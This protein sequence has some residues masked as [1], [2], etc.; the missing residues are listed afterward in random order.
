MLLTHDIVSD[1]QEP[2]FTYFFGVR[3]AGCYGVVNVSNGQSTLFV[4]KLH[5]DYATWMGRLWTCNDF[6][7]RYGV[8]DVKYVDEVSELSEIVGLTFFKLFLWGKVI[9][10]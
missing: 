4:P 2:F 1:L 7:S 5:E 10:F 9:S 3:E 6:K 8:D